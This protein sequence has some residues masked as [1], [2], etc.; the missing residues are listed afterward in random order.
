VVVYAV[1]CEPVSKLKFPANREINR[2]F[3]DLR[4]FGDDICTKNPCAAAGSEQ[5]PAAINREII[6]GNRDF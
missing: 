1:I 5:F 2:E 6:S 4:V 3:Y